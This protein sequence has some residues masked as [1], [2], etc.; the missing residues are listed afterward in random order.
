MESG[1]II[2]ATVQW[3]YERK[4]KSDIR[5][6]TEAFSPAAC[7]I[8]YLYTQRL[9]F[10]LQSNSSKRRYKT[11]VKGRVKWFSDQKRL[12]IYHHR[13]WGRCFCASFQHRGN[14]LQKP[15]R[16][17]RSGVQPGERAKR[18]SGWKRCNTFN[19]INQQSKIKNQKWNRGRGSQVIWELFFCRS[20][21]SNSH[22]KS[23]Q[24]EPKYKKSRLLPMNC[25]IHW[26]RL[27][28][29]YPSQAGILCVPQCLNRREL[30]CP[31]CRVVAEKD[32]DARPRE[33]SD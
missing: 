24:T 33:Y 5:F 21:T 19:Q 29:G 20:I 16:R 9:D 8:L 13:W 26:L 4:F 25:Q 30:R 22:R 3:K 14:W 10:H 17:P 7:C 32:A 31:A 12:W 11:M 1:I 2:D 23:F 6:K 15:L 28:Y 27:G 18:L